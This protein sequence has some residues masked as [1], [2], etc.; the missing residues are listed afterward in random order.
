MT[1][2][3]TSIDGEFIEPDDAKVSVF[4]H[5]FLFGDSIYEVVRTVDGKLFAADRHL[6]RLH[7]SAE[8]LLLEI[9]RPDDWFIDHLR[10]MHARALWDG[11]SYLRL[12]VTRGVGLIDLHPESCDAARVVGIAKALTVWADEAYAHG[13]KVILSGV[14]RNPKAATDPAIKSGNYLNNVLALM[15]ARKEGA[16]EA[17]MLNMED[18]VSEA[19]TSNV[20]IV[21]EGKVRTPALGEGIL[22]GVT[23]GFIIE[24]CS[25]LGIE[26]QEG[27]LTRADL[28]GAD[29]AFITSSTRDVMPIASIGE[30]K[31]TRPPGK[32][33]L[34]IANAY[35]DVLREPGN[36]C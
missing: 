28:L 2:Y 24:I 1:Q 18:H 27:T 14:R 3:V 32:L 17:I 23:R 29:E 21:A 15:E 33:T 36:L 16:V 19:T 35:H 31:L 12:V 25:K 9:P 10:A 11:E 8:R 30:V 34:R 4:D 26:C 13:C 6:K 5:G 7:A 20:F 22:A